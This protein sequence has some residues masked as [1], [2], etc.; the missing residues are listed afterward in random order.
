MVMFIVALA[1]FWGLIGTW[2]HIKETEGQ[3]ELSKPLNLFS[4]AHTSEYIS[5][6]SLSN[7]V[8]V[9]SYCWAINLQI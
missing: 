4:Y 1:D 2:A 7:Q 6:C 3:E 8:S 9:F 5:L